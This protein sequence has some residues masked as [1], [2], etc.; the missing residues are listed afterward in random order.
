M[1][2]LYESKIFPSLTMVILRGKTFLLKNLS[3]AI[4]GCDV[5]I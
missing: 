5:C 3:N 1:D 2:R 4:D